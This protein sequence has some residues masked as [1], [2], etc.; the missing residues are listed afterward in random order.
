MKKINIIG[1][2][3]MGS[4]IANLF[5]ILG[6]QVYVW[7]RNKIDKEHLLRQKKLILKLIK[8]EDRKGSI[9]ILDK[10]ESLEDNITIECLAE[11]IELKK[12]YFNKIIKKVSKE[13]FSNTSSIKT[14]LINDKLNLL[15][16]FNPIS[17]KI[18]EYNSFKKLS[19]EAKEIFSELE[20]LN[21]DLIEVGNFTGFAFN[22]ILFAEISNFFFLIEKE[23][24]E[25]NKLIKVFKRINHNLD[26]LN[27]LDIIGIDTSAKI[28]ENL[29][30]EYNFYVPEILNH[31]LSKKIFGK[32]NKTSIKKIFNST[33]YPTK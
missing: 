31:C 4:Q 1:C 12:D 3:L 27:T 25:K 21:F 15:H 6:Y 10:L 16:F 33:N 32:K 13:I 28:M 5:S 24:I 26:I 23:K 8:I 2:G 17:L 30:R 18:V 9:H 14:N 22:K 19:N 11:D 7:N 29:K 20:A